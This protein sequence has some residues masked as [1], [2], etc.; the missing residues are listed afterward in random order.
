LRSNVYIYK[1][2]PYYIVEE[3]SIKVGGTWI[4]CIIYATL[5]ENPDGELW[6]R[7]KE[8]FFNLFEKTEAI[9]EDDNVY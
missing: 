5:Y 6:V 1:E 8:D 4:P 2:K 9:Y 3:T 7:F